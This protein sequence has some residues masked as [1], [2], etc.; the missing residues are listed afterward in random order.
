MSARTEDLPP[1]PRRST[2][3]RLFVYSALGMVALVIIAVLIALLCLRSERFNRFLA[4]EIEKAL[5]AYGLRA[6]VEKVEPEFGSSAV[7][8]RN[9][10]LFNR[11]TGQLIATIDRARAS[12]TI[13]DP[14][15][16]RLRREI[17]FDR[18]E[19]GA[20]DLWAVFDQQGQSNFQ[21]LRRPPPVRRRSTSDY[22]GLVG[23]L[24]KAMIHFTDRKRD[25]IGDLRDLT[26]EARPVEG[27]DPPKVEARLASGKG[28]I[29]RN[30][31]KMA[32]ESVEFIG[33]VM[34]SGAEIERMT[35][36][37][38]MGEVTASG[39]LDDWRSPRYQVDTGAWAWL[40]EVLAIFAPAGAAPEVIAYE[41]PVATSPGIVPAGTAPGA[42]AP[43]RPVANDPGGAPT[44]TVSGALATGAASKLP[45]KGLTSFNGRIEG[46]GARW[47]AI[48]QAGSDEL[49]AYG[50]TFRDARVERARLDSQDGRWTFSTGQAQARSVSA[51]G[52]ELTNATASNVKGTI[53]RGQTRITSDQVT[54]ASINIG[55][56]GKIG[57]AGK[58]GKAGWNEFSEI[59]LRDVSAIYE[60]RQGKGQWTF[61]SSMG[62]AR[63]GVAGE[64][65]FTDASASKLSGTLEVGQTSVCPQPGQTRV[66]PTYSARFTSGQASAKLLKAGQSEFNEVT[67]RDLN[68]AFGSGASK[69]E[70]TFSIGQAQ[71]RSGVAGGT[72]LTNASVSKVDGTVVDGRAQ[73]S[74]DQATVERAKIRTAPGAVATGTAPG[75]VATGTVPGAVAT[76]TNTINE[77]T[78]RDLKTTFGSDASKGE[79]TFS[80]G[81]TQARSGV[82]E[83]VK[84][85]TAS[86]SNVSG[87]VAGGR[88]R[89]TS[90]QATFEH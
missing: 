74:S 86:T 23:S 2:R 68:T 11:Q 6:E 51:G 10:K 19:L 76:G 80:I 71:A 26:I 82:V 36:R 34:E 75:A 63:L 3:R 25:L 12:F 77:T 41:P 64:I 58:F 24:N 53:V 66:C 27:A 20:V 18:L 67:A 49:A 87:T 45:L 73:V 90:G 81:Q 83:G 46:D 9:L 13:R 43:G 50:I 32:I 88:A 57:K 16:L 70:W 35:L 52:V 38:P 59:K 30:G 79:W 55:E 61:S 44:G 7:T 78:A 21:G 40:E 89:I 31:H 62:H 4:I 14:F 1:R 39:R 22:S 15:A 33:R 47:S 56:G 72:E 37:S 28:A 69:G 17:V 84:F 8:L 5:E 85:I 29:V 42:V 60:S 48:G 65:E 54:V